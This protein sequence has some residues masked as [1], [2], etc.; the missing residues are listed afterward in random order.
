MEIEKNIPLPKER[1]RYPIKDMEIGDSILIPNYG[2]ANSSLRKFRK[3]GWKF[4]RRQE[5]AKIR[6]WRT[7]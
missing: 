2:N 5:N 1:I 7:K 3:L 4:T 6:L